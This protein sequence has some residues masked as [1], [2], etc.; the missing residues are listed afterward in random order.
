MIIGKLTCE[1]CGCD[2]TSLYGY[3]LAVRGTIRNQQTQTELAKVKKEFG[4]EDFYWCWSCTAK[5]FG[6]K[7]LTV[8]KIETALPQTKTVDTAQTFTIESK[9]DKK[10]PMRA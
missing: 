2:C 3:A 8:D 7:P 1:S 4:K 9:S 10:S 6:A 5:A